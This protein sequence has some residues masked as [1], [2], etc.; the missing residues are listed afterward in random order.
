MNVE[1][2]GYSPVRASGPS[3]SAAAFCATARTAPVDGSI[4]TITA[5]CCIGARTASARVCRSRSSVV[6]RSGAGGPSAPATRRALPSPDT[7]RT[8]QPAD[9]SC[10]SCHS[11]PSPDSTG[12]ARV[13]STVSNRV[14]R[15]R[16]TPGQRGEL[17]FDRREVR[18]PEGHRRHGL[19][20]RGGDVGGKRL[21]GDR[22]RGRRQQGRD[23]R[24]VGGGIEAHQRHDLL[25]EDRLPAA[26][27]HRRRR[28]HRGRV[29]QGG[30]GGQVRGEQRRIPL[31]A[32]AL[33]VEVHRTAGRAVRPVPPGAEGPRDV[34][35]ERARVPP[36]RRGS[37]RGGP[38]RTR[39]RRDRRTRRRSSWPP[40]RGRW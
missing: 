23:G 12:E 30:A 28:T 5:G 2:G 14:C 4:A 1:P 34:E 33:R 20:R 9:A 17:R 10:P 38:C 19:A 11:S 7:S 13:R 37:R 27:E 35:V 40:P 15:T 22:G 36:C 3:A 21:R 16:V 29:A 26:V 39:R 24:R 6:C 31:D 18:L 25:F 32:P 8:A